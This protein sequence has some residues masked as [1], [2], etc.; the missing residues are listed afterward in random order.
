M[1]VLV[2]GARGAIARNV[3]AQLLESGTPV[4]AASRVPGATAL[5]AGVDPVRVD[6]TAPET[7]APALE[8]VEQVFLYAAHEGLDEFLTA[9]KEAGVKH[10]VLLS[11][12]AV[13]M[14][15]VPNNPI[16]SLHSG[17]ERLIEASGLPWTF[18]RPGMFATNSLWWADS[19]RNEGVVRL[20]YPDAPVNPIHE[21][22]IAEAA[23]TTLV[24][25]GHE[26]RTYVI[27]GPGHLSQRRQVELIGE[28]IGREIAV[29]ELPR[30]VA[31]KF[32]PEPVLDMLAAGSTEIWGPTSEAVTGRPARTYADWTVD[33][34]ADFR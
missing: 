18:V 21:R 2:T 13:T 8:G 11:S 5:P 6:F 30:E 14:D 12:A 34:A 33:H 19:I 20:P 31:A 3:I 25:G 22:D 24:E 16:L 17:A 10:L 9:A 28:A 27:D 32:M 15:T 7:L 26:G 23:Y 29:E 1:T 4:R